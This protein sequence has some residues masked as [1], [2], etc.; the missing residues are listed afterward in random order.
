MSWASSTSAVCWTCRLS[1]VQ[2]FRGASYRWVS[3]H[4]PIGKG[5]VA[6]KPKV[7]HL[8]PLTFGRPCLTLLSLPD[9][10]LEPNRLNKLKEW[11]SPLDSQSS[12]WSGFLQSG[13]WVFFLLT[14]GESR[15]R[16]VQTAKGQ[17]F[18]S[19]L[20]SAGEVYRSFAEVDHSPTEQVQIYDVANMEETKQPSEL[21][22]LF[23]MY[24]PKTKINFQII[25][26]TSNLGLT[27]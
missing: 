9:A 20:S 15:L 4:D 27:W 18:V 2:F 16:H 5:N 19:Q 26:T 23:E 22:S 25:I 14:L 6:W 24:K 8:P 12:L 13:S 7:R 21:S 10:A 3:V 1:S 11:L 17:T